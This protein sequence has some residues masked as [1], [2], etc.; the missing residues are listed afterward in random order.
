MLTG[1]YDVQNI[2]AEPGGQCGEIETAIIFSKN[3]LARG[4]LIVVVHENH[5]VFLAPQR[6]LI[7][8]DILA[9]F[10]GLP[11]GMYDIIAFDLERDGLPAMHSSK[12]DNFELMIQCGSAFGKCNYS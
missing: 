1:T 5:M 10:N 7:Q 11:A 9:T 4:C 12:S 2:I 8:K 6:S 3:S